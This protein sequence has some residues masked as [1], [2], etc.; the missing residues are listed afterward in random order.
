MARDSL[1]CAAPM[2]PAARVSEASVPGVEPAPAPGRPA[3]DAVAARGIRREP[4]APIAPATVESTAGNC[5]EPSTRLPSAEGAVPAPASLDPCE[6]PISSTAAWPWPQAV[7]SHQAPLLF[8]VNALL[9]D[10]LYPDFT[11]PRDPGLPV[12]LWALLPALAQ[13]WRLPADGLQAALQQHCP[14]W[15]A[16]EVMPAAPGAPAGRWPEW[17]PAYARTLRRRLCRR[18]RL[19]PA[20]WPQALTLARPARLWI[21]EGEWVAEFDL[22]AHDVSWRL[23]GLD[24]DPGW[25]PSAGC[26]LRFSFV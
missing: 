15:T 7:L 21:S 6:P 24:R 26:T 20:A 23:A 10:G 17:L 8:I 16:P 13:A 1:E 11:Q 2:R 5:A 22:N 19:R 3:P 25:L 12:P 14:D 18:L 4:A 9:E